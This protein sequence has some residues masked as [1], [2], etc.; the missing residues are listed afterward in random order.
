MVAEGLD[1]Q[2]NTQRP[3]MFI[4]LNSRGTLP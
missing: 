2:A 3:I 4:M 1:S